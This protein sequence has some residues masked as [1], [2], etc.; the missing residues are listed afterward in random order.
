MLRLH[1]SCNQGSL[2]FSSRCIYIIFAKVCTSVGIMASVTS[3]RRDGSSDLKCNHATARQHVLPLIA[4]QQ[5]LVSCAAII[6]I[7][8]RTVV[9]VIIFIIV[10]VI[11]VRLLAL[12]HR[13]AAMCKLQCAPLQPASPKH[14]IKRHNKTSSQMIQGFWNAQVTFKLQPRWSQPFWQ[15]CLQHFCKCLHICGHSGQH[16]QNILSEKHN[17]HLNLDDSRV[18]KCSGYIQIATEVVTPLM[19]GVFAILLHKF[20]PL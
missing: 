15:V 4:C 19:A 3:G 16:D 18:L 17:P 8:L 1:L 2:T 11:A 20:A 9:A 10:V 13:Y 14:I 7:T 5:A 12:R 6:Y